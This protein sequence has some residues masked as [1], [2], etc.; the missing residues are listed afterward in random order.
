MIKFFLF[1][2]L[3]CF[4]L[5]RVCAG[6]GADYVLQAGHRGLRGQVTV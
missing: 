1:I 5:Y 3:V 2:F 4:V 6:G